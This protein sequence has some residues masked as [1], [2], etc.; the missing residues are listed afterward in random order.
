[1][2]DET[3]SKLTSDPLILSMTEGKVHVNSDVSPSLKLLSKS[4]IIAELA[5]IP[6][7]LAQPNTKAKL[8]WSLGVSRLVSPRLS[9]LSSIIPKQVFNG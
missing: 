2:E 9:W 8:C 3:S 5:E 4:D 1:M 6:T 7:A